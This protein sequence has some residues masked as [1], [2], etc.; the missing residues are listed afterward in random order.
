MEVLADFSPTNDALELTAQLTRESSRHHSHQVA[1]ASKPVDESIVKKHGQ[2]TARKVAKGAIAIV[3][4]KV[5]DQSL[6]KAI[7]HAISTEY[8]KCVALIGTGCEYR[9][10]TV[11]KVDVG[12]ICSPLLTRDLIQQITQAHSGQ[13]ANL[14]R[15]FGVSVG[16]F[17]LLLLASW[18]EF[19]SDARTISLGMQIRGAVIDLISRKSMRLS[20]KARI[21]MTSGR[22][23][24]MVSADASYLVSWREISL[25]A[26]LAHHASS[27]GGCV[28]PANRCWNRLADIRSRILCISRLSSESKCEPADQV[29]ALSAPFQWYMFKRMYRYRD[30]QQKVVDQRVRIL[31]EV[32]GSIRAVKLYA[33]ETYFSQ[34]ISS[35]RKEELAMLQQNGVSRAFTTATMAFVPILAA[36]GKSNI[37]S[38]NQCL[39]LHMRSLAT[40]SSQESSLRLYNSTIN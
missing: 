28:D 27:R 14:G 24:T 38:A 8:W 35:K 32:I 15:M 12:R 39:S 5:Y 33:Y 25:I 31:S 13:P 20:N 6:S 37:D 40:T 3:D 36:I 30:A 22:I 7:Y 34:K 1:A 17:L 11:L 21:K 23:N 19:H 16:N 9:T 18:L 2:R 10:E 26:G 4:G 29:L